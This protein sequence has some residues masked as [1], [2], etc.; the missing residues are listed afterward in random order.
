MPT[1]PPLNSV[2]PPHTLMCTRT[3]TKSASSRP[4]AH[5]PVYLV[6]CHP[7]PHCAVRRVEHLS[8]HQAGLPNASQLRRRA[9]RHCGQRGKG[10]GRRILMR[11][12]AVGCRLCWRAGDA[13]RAAPPAA[14]RPA[15][16]PCAAPACAAPGPG[17]TRALLLALDLRHRVAVVSIVRPH[18][19][20]RDLR[21]DGKVTT[22]RDQLRRAPKQH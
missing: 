3:R 22:A 21:P 12:A 6:R 10:A 20:R 14:T 13:A 5:H 1:A 19:V 7:R 9:D 4:G 11:P 15:S 17:L 16:A 8:P 18:N 2:A